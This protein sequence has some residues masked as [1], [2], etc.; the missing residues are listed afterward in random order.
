LI[1]EKIQYPDGV[2]Q[3]ITENGTRIYTTHPDGVIELV[4][5]EMVSK[6]YKNGIIKM[7]FPNGSE[8]TRWPNGQIRIKDA[9]VIQASI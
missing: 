9:T 6:L 5:E 8:E 1:K 2:V 3:Q 4:T 7:T